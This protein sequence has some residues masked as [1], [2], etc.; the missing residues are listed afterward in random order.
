[1]GESCCFLTI[2]SLLLL[3]SAVR[4]Y[5]SNQSC[6]LLMKDVTSLPEV[7]KAE[8]N[9]ANSHVLKCFYY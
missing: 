2:V 4:I 8:L 7:I 3:F 9:L 1:M 6:V 5:L